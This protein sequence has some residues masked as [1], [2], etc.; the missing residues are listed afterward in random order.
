MYLRVLIMLPKN[1][2]KSD[3]GSDITICPTVLSTR[4]CIELHRSFANTLES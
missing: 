1:S 3:D 2:H 4:N